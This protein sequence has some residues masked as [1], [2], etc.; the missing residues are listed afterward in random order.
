LAASSFKKRDVHKWY[1]KWSV[2]MTCHKLYNFTALKWYYNTSQF[3]LS[4]QISLYKWPIG[5]HVILTLPLTLT[6]KL[7]FQFSE[8]N[9]G[10][11]E[12][13]FQYVKITLLALLKQTGGTRTGCVFTGILSVRNKVELVANEIISTCRNHRKKCKEILQIFYYLVSR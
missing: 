2:R 5:F 4:N 10:F 7:A 12:I 6:W 3:E 11:C 9:G 8:W 1:Y 13:F